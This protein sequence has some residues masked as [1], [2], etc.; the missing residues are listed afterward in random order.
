MDYAAA[1][2]EGYC[3]GYQEDHDVRCIDKTGRGS[4]LRNST[5][6][7]LTIFLVEDRTDKSEHQG[8]LYTCVSFVSDLNNKAEAE[9]LRTTYIYIEYP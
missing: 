6:N 9:D 8:R 1:D 7:E 5:D 2:Y 4:A 3:D